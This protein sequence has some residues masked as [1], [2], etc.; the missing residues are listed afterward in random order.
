MTCVLCQMKG[1]PVYSILS[2]LL[3]SRIATW[4]IGVVTMGTI[5][6]LLNVYIVYHFQHDM[7]TSQHG[8]ETGTSEALHH[9]TPAPTVWIYH[10][11][12]ST[13]LTATDIFLCY[14][15]SLLTPMH[16]NYRSVLL[17]M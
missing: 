10:K 1:Q 5:L 8:V 9:S 4:L 17:V 6:T 7:E 12:V 16:N 15:H 14:L 2:C 3:R 13:V 11:T